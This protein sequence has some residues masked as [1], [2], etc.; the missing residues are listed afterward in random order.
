[1]ERF[2]KINGPPRP[3]KAVE[4]EKCG[5]EIRMRGWARIENKGKTIIKTYQCCGCRDGEKENQV[6]S[7]T[8]GLARES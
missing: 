1:M 5:K 6:N 4:C 7:R 2:E 3:F 8:K